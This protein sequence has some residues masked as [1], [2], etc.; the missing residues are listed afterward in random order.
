VVV[1]VPTEHLKTQWAN[2][3]AK[4]GLQLD[5]AATN[6]NGFEA[7]DFHGAVLTYGQVAAQPELHRLGCDRT[8][9]LVILDEVHHT[10]EERAWG[11]TVR[12]AF[13]PAAR[14]LCLSGTPFRSDNNPIP[15]V[16]YDDSGKSVPDF[17]YGYGPAIRDGVCR[18]VDFH[19]YD[20]EMWLSGVSAQAVA[21][22]S[23]RYAKRAAIYRA[24]LVIAAAMIWLNDSQGRAGPRSAR[25]R[26]PSARRPGRGHDLRFL[27]HR[28]L[29]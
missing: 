22:P 7:R 8:P 11:D 1:V 23:H 27:H 17:S 4:T 9:T 3:A 26:G 25:T 2:A 19:F 18:Q 15:F 16:R 28:P 21:G 20:G 10:G 5:P 12:T 6:A 29:P 13:E 14:R 24:N